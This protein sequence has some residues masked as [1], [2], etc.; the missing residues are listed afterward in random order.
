[1]SSLGIM[2]CN[3]PGLCPVKV[4]NSG[5][6]IHTGAWNQLS[7]LSL[8]TTKIVPHYQMLAIHPE[9]CFSFRFLPRG[10]KDGSGCTKFWTEQS[11]A[12]LSVISFPCTP[13]SKDTQ[14]SPT[15]CWV[16]MSINAFWHCYT[17][18]L[19]YTRL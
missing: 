12:S 5:L 6:C 7:R 17:M 2:F 8:S 13:A 1:M 15:V 4:Q 3:N 19:Y 16:E 11:F 10:P 14:Y 9:F 18:T